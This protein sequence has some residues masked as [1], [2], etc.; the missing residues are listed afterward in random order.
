MTTTVFNTKF[1]EIENKIPDHAKY[2]STPEF[3]KFA[4]SVIDTELKQVN[5]A[6]NNHVNAVSQPANKNKEK[7]EKLQTFD[8]KLFSW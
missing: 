3:N 4:F 8:F 5:L 7:I 2:I 1:G 6:I